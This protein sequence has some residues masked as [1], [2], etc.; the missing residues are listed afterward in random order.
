MTQFT[1]LYKKNWLFWKRD[2][3]CCTCQIVC[4][5][6]FGLLFTLIKVLSGDNTV[7]KDAALY[8]NNPRFDIK[9]PFLFQDGVS[10]T[11]ANDKA[12]LDSVVTYINTLKANKVMIM[13]DCNEV[14]DRASR[15]K[16]GDVA[17]ITKNAV[18]SENLNYFFNKLGFGTRTFNSV[19]DLNNFI[20]TV[21]YGQRLKPDNKPDIVCF[22]VSFN[23]DSGNKWSY[24][25]HF[26]SSGNPARY[27]L[28]D[29]SSHQEITFQEEDISRDPSY[30][31][32]L[33]AG[34]SVIQNVIDSLILRSATGNAQAHIRARMVNMPTEAFSSS[35]VFGLTFG[36]RIDILLLVPLLF[37]YLDYTFKLV[38]EKEKKITENLRNMGMSLMPHYLSWFAFYSTVSFALSTLWTIITKFTFFKNSDFI[39]ILLLYY[40]TSLALLG[41]SQIVSALFSDAKSGVLGALCVYLTLFGLTFVQYAIDRP[42][43]AV[44]NILAL[45]P[46]AG[47]QFALSGSVALEFYN[48][49]GI[50]FTNAWEKVHNFR[51]GTFLII[52]TIEAFFLF[53]IGVYLDLLKTGEIGLKKHPLFCF[54]VKN[55]KE[56]DT[57]KHI[58][59]DEKYKKENYE[60][61]T[62]D[63][64]DRL[65]ND[66]SNTVKIRN[67]HKTDS[68]GKVL[69]QN[70]EVD[71]FVHQTVSLLGDHSSGKDAFIQAVIGTVK[72]T[73]GSVEVFNFDTR[74]EAKKAREFFGIC[75]E[76]DAIY[77]RLTCKE[78]LKI[79]YRLKQVWKGLESEQEIER[80]LDDFGLLSKKHHQ[81]RNLSVSQ[82]RRLSLAI[83]FL[84]HNKLVLLKSPTQ[85][86]D[87]YSRKSVWDVIRKYNQQKLILLDTYSPEENEYLADKYA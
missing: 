81:T 30:A 72:P 19:A 47:M 50:G 69:L 24:N 7:S 85:G 45:N 58:E 39:L 54:G 31:E 79:Y 21:E 64:I 10:N 60:E 75:P 3:C 14:P 48:D 22:A 17:I 80:I 76:V 78:H 83:A 29:P 13:K 63:L 53:G 34:Y 41:V 42:S 66:P 23:E 67:L 62:P 61:L 35:I 86:M 1:T 20:T 49:T 9:L 25:L 38:K 6:A 40:L 26:N 73:Q 74:T 43:E 33:S 5:V 37:V 15:Q 68:K 18:M 55:K 2:T 57:G 77:E 46:L 32:Y 12:Y 4:A 11:F 65:K 36:G 70:I 51:F 84:N 44:L 56:I 16:G 52:T 87:P 71:M 28:P 8:L 27:D 82:Q 59:V